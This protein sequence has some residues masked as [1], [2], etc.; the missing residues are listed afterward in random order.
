MI[1]IAQV[2]DVS[3]LLEYGAGVAAI[4]L[5]LWLVRHVTTRTIPTL[6]KD[7]RE[8]L[9]DQAETFERMNRETRQEFRE[10]LENDRR[11][12]HEREESLRN[13]FREALREA[14]P[15]GNHNTAGSKQ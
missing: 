12:H 13:E 3:R 8:S 5:V 6:V 14:A 11:M 7:F 4:G 15:Q 1:L 9:K 10:I 2:T